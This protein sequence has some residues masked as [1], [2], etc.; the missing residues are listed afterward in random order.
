MIDWA[1]K[2]ENQ[3]VDGQQGEDKDFLPLL[4][5]ISK[6][7]KLS[8]IPNALGWASLPTTKAGQLQTRGNLNTALQSIAQ[9]I[10]LFFC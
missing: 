7:F 2:F 6:I 4:L 3:L 9:S 8:T 10:L 5:L 1:G